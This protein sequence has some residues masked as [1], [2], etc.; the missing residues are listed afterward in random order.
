MTTTNEKARL[1]FSYDEFEQMFEEENDFA[2]QTFDSER[3][4][5]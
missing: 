4:C 5:L 1:E 2:N 3:R